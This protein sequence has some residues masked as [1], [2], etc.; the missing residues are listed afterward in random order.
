M[1]RLA[2]HGGCNW[3]GCQECFPDFKMITPDQYIDQVEKL[4]SQ[5]RKGLMT[6]KEFFIELA[7]IDLS[8]DNFNHADPGAYRLSV[9]FPEE[10]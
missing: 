7:I 10:R 3:R 6:Q 5:F 9:M 2:P 8:V 4:I 1:T